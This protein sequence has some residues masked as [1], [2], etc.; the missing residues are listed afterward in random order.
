MYAN[1]RSSCLSWQEVSVISI[2]Q[3]QLNSYPS[4]SRFAETEVTVVLTLMILRYKVTVKEEA[5]FAGKTL[6]QRKERILR[7][8][9]IL[10]LTY[11]N[12][13]FWTILTSHR[14]ALD[15]FVF[16]W[17]LRNGNRTSESHSFIELKLNTCSAGLGSTS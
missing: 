15:L 12:E 7:T 3:H 4:S 2:M 10:T 9:N 17:Y 8:K 14:H 16:L 1:V 13:H 11:V 6:E 5:Q